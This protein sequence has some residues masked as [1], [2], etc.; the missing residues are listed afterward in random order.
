MYVC[1]GNL[2]ASGGLDDVCSIF[3]VSSDSLSTL[4]W[5]DDLKARKI[6]Y[7]HE[8]YLTA[9][10][11][12]EDNEI[13]TS[14]GDKSIR[15]WN[16]EKGLEIAS[17]CDG[18]IKDVLDLSACV[19]NRSVLSSSVDGTVKVW[20]LRAKECQMTFAVS[21]TSDVNTVEWFPDELGRT[22]ACG[23][24]DGMF[25]HTMCARAM[26]MCVCVMVLCIVYD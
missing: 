8:G 14:S 13:L 1:V 2:F 6:L 12:L 26:R 22:F 24:D 25:C 11:F 4:E 5:S 21:M 3:D 23:S 16:I 19:A 17:F 7:G 10:Q 15:W 9:A 18:H 20:D